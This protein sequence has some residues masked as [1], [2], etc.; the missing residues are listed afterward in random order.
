M[1]ATAQPTVQAG[2][3]GLEIREPT[4]TQ[5]LLLDCPFGD[6]VAIVSA[7]G[8]GKSWGIALLTARDAAHF[9]TNYSC[10]ITRTTYQGLA[11]IQQLLERYYK[12]AFPGTTYSGADRTFRLGGKGEPFGRVELGY[13]GSGPV[14]Q[15]KSLN[16]YQGRSFLCHIADEAGNF[17]DFTFLDTARATLRGPKGLPTRQVILGNPGG[18]LHPLLQSRY[19]IPAGFP[20]AGRASRFWSEDLEKF[21][22]FATFTA[23]SNQHLELDQYIRNIRVAAG[24]DPALLDAWL[25]G[26]LDV[27]IAGSFYGSSYSVKRSLH[28]VNPG[29]ISQQDLKR[30]FVCLDHGIAAPTVAYLCL[31]E[32]EFAPKGSIL[33][34]DE[35]YVA[36]STAGGQR[37]W[38]RGAYLSNAE[39]ASGIIEWLA[40]WGL[41]PGT[42]KI[43]ADDA[44]F[45]ANGSDRG[46]TA[47]DFRH[48]G[49]PLFRA[50]KMEARESNGL[51]VVRT[52]LHAAGRD[53]ETPW[54]IWTKAC[55]GWMNTV[56]TLPRHPR[57][58]ELIADGVANHALDALR[59]GVMWYQSRHRSAIK[60]G[61]PHPIM[62]GL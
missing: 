17:F 13:T 41:S 26:R 47:G 44:V 12:H 37:N 2:I 40:R 29:G 60:G 62:W 35:F 7:R 32:P 30:A 59:Y 58:V 53:P 38:T 52:M 61:A 16:V 21:C 8:T 54:L 45:N 6:D 23:A 28:D 46:S 3:A 5:K 24:D 15:V 39:Q 33:M 4:L 43:V 10:L 14:E 9:K 19:G 25:H 51:G 31:P 18:P 1:T 48:A 27:D 56:P 55:E 49:C 36:A 34:L 42:T 50:G 11:E 20:E 57:N 22:I